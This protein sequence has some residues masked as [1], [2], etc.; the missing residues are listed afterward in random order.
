MVNQSDLYGYI[1]SMQLKRGHV[2]EIN[3]LKL[4]VHPMRCYSGN[5]SSCRHFP[6][7]NQDQVARR[8]HSFVGE[9]IDTTQH[10]SVNV[11]FVP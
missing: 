1:Q 4:A 6:Q 7:F 8:T 3:R 2:F 9:N 11:P 10:N 5:V